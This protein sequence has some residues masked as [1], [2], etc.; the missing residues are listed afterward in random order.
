MSDHYPKVLRSV[1]E[2]LKK[3]PGIGQKGAERLAFFL[4]KREEEKVLQ[5]ADALVRLKKQV[6]VCSVCHSLCERNPCDVCSSAGR[7]RSTIC[8][9][10]ESNDMFFIEKVGDFRGVYHVLQG[11]ISPGHGVGPSDLKVESLIQRCQSSDVQEVI[12]ATN[13]NM[14]GETTALY[15]QRV[16]SR[17]GLTISRIARGIPVGGELE[18]VDEVTLLKAIQGRTLL[19]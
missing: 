5:L 9:V 13:P 2:E 12:I 1:I 10:E 8:V 15:L 18:Y 14:D 19:T 3:L 7:D 6:S 17:E 11:V 16:L 4:I